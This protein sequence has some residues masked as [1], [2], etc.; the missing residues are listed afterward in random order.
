MVYHPNYPDTHTYQFKFTRLPSKNPKAFINFLIYS[1]QKDEITPTIKI[2]RGD[3]SSPD[4]SCEMRVQTSTQHEDANVKH[5]NKN[6]SVY[7]GELKMT[8]AGTCV[9]N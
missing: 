8:E 1:Q 7:K 6:Q 4:S 9:A 5:A 3:A 2:Q